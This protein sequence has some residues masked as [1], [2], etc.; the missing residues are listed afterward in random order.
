MYLS[1]DWYYMQMMRRTYEAS[2]LATTATPAKI[3]GETR[4]YMP[5]EELRP[6][7]YLTQAL[8]IAFDDNGRK[9]RGSSGIELYVF[10]SKNLILP[11]NRAKVIEQG[12]AP[13]TLSIVPHLQ[14]KVSGN[15]IG[16]NSLAALDFAAN[17]FLKR[18]IYYASSGNE[19]DFIM[20]VDGNLRQEGL[21][22]QLVPENTAKMPVNINKT[23]DLLVNKFRYRGINDPK[24]YMDET[25][26]RTVGYYRST[27]FRLADILKIK[28]DKE[29]LK[30]LMEKYHEAIPEM[31]IVNI[32]HTPYGGISN[33]A[34][35][36]YFHAELDGYGVSLAQR[37]IDEY[38]KEY[39]YY[40]GL[41]EKAS[42]EY[43]LSRVCQGIANLTDILKRYNQT[44]LHKQTG[45]LFNE[46]RESLGAY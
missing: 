32:H 26:R 1:S 23:F 28:N 39:S 10:P 5:V 43:E 3:I 9:F 18:P 15:S 19:P 24:V 4:A 20:G 12:L 38:G 11:V 44:D 45:D 46:I 29:R 34:V 21:A 40:S 13:D 33:P 2:P 36:Y 6:S 37:L 25:A 16:K 22:R 35:E 27:F 30:Q 8:Q 14:F 41:I 17:N 31:D 7:L 42:V